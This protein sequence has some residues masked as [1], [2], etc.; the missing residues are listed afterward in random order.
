MIS[1]HVELKNEADE[2]MVQ[3]LFQGYQSPNAV[4]GLPTAPQK[5]VLF[6]EDPLRPQPRLDV[7]AGSPDRARGMAVTVG[8]LSVDG[9]IIRFVTLSNNLV[10]GAAGGSILNAELASR[11]NLL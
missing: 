2:E 3:S 4:K 1:V 8:R 10:R 7:N 6:S 11:E 9:P 5:P